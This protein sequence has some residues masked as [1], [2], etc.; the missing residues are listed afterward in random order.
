MDILANGVHESL[1]PGRFFQHT[2]YLYR[3]PIFLELS[4]VAT[5]GFVIL[6][7]SNTRVTG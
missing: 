4:T 5:S 2:K 1:E 3:H 7:E 6:G